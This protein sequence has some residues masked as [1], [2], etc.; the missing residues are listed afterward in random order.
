MTPRRRTRRGRSAILV[1][2]A[3]LA[4]LAPP[5]AWAPAW[6]GGG[7]SCGLVAT[8]LAFGRYVPF[9]NAPADFAA[10]ITVTCTATG[11]SPV[12][13]QAS[14][15]LVDTGGPSARQLTDGPYA[16]R[17]QLYVDPART[18]PWR[19]AGGAGGNVAVSGVVGLT[20]PFRQAVTLYGRIPARQSGA[21]VGTYADQVTVMLSY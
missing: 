5:P 3:L 20:T 6:A 11:T 16:L 19:S 15:S 10:T 1:A 17:Y 4:A 12:P 2:V 21:H 18:V 9:S 14:I 7:L 8:P 13:L